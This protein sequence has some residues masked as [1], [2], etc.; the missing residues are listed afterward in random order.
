MLKINA[1]KPQDL[2]PPIC[3]KHM[4]EWM[5]E[6]LYLKYLPQGFSGFFL[7]GGG[8]MGV[9]VQGEAGREVS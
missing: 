1:L 3:N 8:D 4:G 7:G 6:S 5:V 2:H 9:G